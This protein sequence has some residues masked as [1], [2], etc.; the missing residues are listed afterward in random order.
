MSYDL[1]KYHLSYCEQIIRGAAAGELTHLE[2]NERLTA[3]RA[4]YAWVREIEPASVPSLVNRYRIRARAVDL[5][6]EQVHRRET[7]SQ[8]P[9]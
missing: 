4:L 6:R 2:E 9:R 1:E 7:G 5:V 8:L 3:A